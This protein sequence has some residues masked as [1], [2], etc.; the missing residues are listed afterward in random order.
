VTFSIVARELATGA[1]GAAVATGT[2]V[3]GGF[4]LHLGADVGAI[5]TQGLSTNPLYGSR[6][7]RLLEAGLTAEDARIHLIGEDDGRD[8]RQLIIVDRNGKTAGWT[9]A[10][11]V[12]ATHV[13]LERDLALAGNWIASPDVVIAA[14]SAFESSGAPTFAGRLIDALTAGESAGGD[15]RGLR[16]AAVRVVSRDHPPIDLRADFDPQPIVRLAEI[17]RATL[18]AD[19]QAFLARVPTLADPMRW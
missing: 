11:N 7:L 17:H 18:D 19:F 10:D 5:A 4:V 16:S 1:L 8:S 6:G 2:P 13:I 15:S 3:V 12:K 14:K 9:G